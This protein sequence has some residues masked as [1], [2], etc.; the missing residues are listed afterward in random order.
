[1]EKFEW[2][3]N[4]FDTPYY[5]I[6]YKD[7]NET[8]AEVFID[9]L[10]AVL[11]LPKEASILD[12]AC[13]KGRYSRHLANKGYKVTGIDLSQKS[14]QYARQ[15]ESKHLSFY[16]HDMRK[17]FRV[18]YYD[19]IFNFFTSF[20]YFKKESEDLKVLRNVKAGL[21]REGIFVLDFF[22]SSYVINHL[23]GK[24]QKTIEG[25]IFNLDKKVEGQR[26][27]KTIHIQDREQSFHFKETVRL[28][29]LRDFE[30]LFEQAG[31]NIIGSFGDYNLSPFDEQ[32]SPRLIIIA[33]PNKA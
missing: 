18:N 4:W 33:Q 27:T 32:S 21:K 11:Q 23:T 14:I 17:L 10:L 3:E 16:T 30:R 31:L 20:G 2:F 7:R 8:E 19:Y 29:T 5:H 1:M 9:R 15:F 28:F 24:E 22:N 6:L 13:G 26:I 12:L 25:I